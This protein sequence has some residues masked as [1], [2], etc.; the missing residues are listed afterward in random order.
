MKLF[1]YLILAAVSA[2]CL[3]LESCSS[4]GYFDVAVPQGVMYSFEAKSLDYVYTPD[5]NTAGVE[6]PVIVSRNITDNGASVP[7][8]STV[9]EGGEALVSCPENV[10][11]NAGESQAKFTI[12]L[13]KDFDINESV[14]VDLAIDPS[15]FGISAKE[16]KR[17]QA[18]P[19]GASEEQKAAYAD[20]MRVFKSDSI[21]YATYQKQLQNVK[22]KLSVKILKDYTWVSIGYGKISDE[23]ETG[24]TTFYD[25]EILRAVEDPNRYEIINPYKEM[26]DLSASSPATEKWKLRVV[27][28]G[29]TMFDYTFEEDGCVYFEDCNTGDYMA[30]YGQYILVCHPIGWKSIRA[31][32]TYSRV[33]S[34]QEN[35]MPAQIGLAPYYYMEGV[36]GWNYTTYTG[37][38]TIVFPGVVLSDYSAAVEYTGRHIDAEGSQS[39]LANVT[40][41]S[42]VA[43]AKV[44]LVPGKG[45]DN[46]FAAAQKLISGEL[47]GLAITEGGEIKLPLDF[48]AESGMYSIVIVAFDKD[49][50]AQ[51][52]NYV[53]FNYVGSG[54]VKETWTP[55]FVGTYTYTLVFGS[56]DE[57]YDDEGLVLSQSDTDPSRY[58]ISHIFYDV[59]FVFVMNEDGTISFED[60]VAAEEYGVYITDMYAAYPDDF[61][62]SNYQNGVFTFSIGYYQNDQFLNYGV[63]KFV[64]TGTYDEASNVRQKAKASSVKSIKTQKTRHARFAPF[65]MVKWTSRF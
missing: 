9:S 31:N 4:D 28:K 65:K 46:A 13:N 27:P 61:A 60:Q 7:V 1:Q 49:G 42:D 48:Y 52:W 24:E 25:V 29:E 57:P 22:C 20:S 18:L 21:A 11:F 51:E 47:E 30:D 62:P 43:S 38:V 54:A 32:S 33:L 50:E 34:Y 36:G 23:F 64:L 59:D 53:Q 2:G 37:V 58:K 5:D 8:I 45:D 15:H 12:K 17:P 35:G 63:E 3:G 26:L 14:T 19:E 44:A 6:I 55:K 39:I 16:P 56:E 41:G 40:L 10:V